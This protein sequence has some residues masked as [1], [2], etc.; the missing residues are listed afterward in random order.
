MIRIISSARIILLPIVQPVLERFPE[1]KDKEKF[2]SFNMKFYNYKWI[3][4]SVSQDAAFCYYCH[5][6]L[7]NELT[8]DP[9]NLSSFITTRYR[10]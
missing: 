5:H 9:N 2:H 8:S 6:F 7:E 4:H 1:N 10:H 3:E